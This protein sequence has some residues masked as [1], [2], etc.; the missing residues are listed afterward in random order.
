M[1]FNYDS[2]PRAVG[3]RE[4]RRRKLTIAAT[5]RYSADSVP[6]RKTLIEGLRSASGSATSVV[7]L[8]GGLLA[9]A[10]RI[11]SDFQT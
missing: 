10:M 3:V 9:D 11:Q 1:S 7:C 5:G 8:I 2:S 4:R 6:G